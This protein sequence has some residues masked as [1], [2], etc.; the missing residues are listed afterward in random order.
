MNQKELLLRA[1][2]LQEKVP[3]RAEFLLGNVEKYGW[4][5]V[6]GSRRD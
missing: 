6:G 4:V 2:I 3:I 1:R 5:D